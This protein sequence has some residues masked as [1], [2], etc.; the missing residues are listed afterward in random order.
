MAAA[1]VETDMKMKLFPRETAR[2]QPLLRNIIV[3]SASLL[4]T[5]CALSGGVE[6][7]DLTVT[8]SATGP[9][10]VR[11]SLPVPRGLIGSNGLV[12]VTI[13]G[14]V[15][16]PVG[17]RVLSWHPTSNGSS[18]SVRRALVTF[19]HRF[20]DSN[21]VRF[22]LR[23]TKTEA[24][25]AA[26]LPV[27]LVV[28]DD[29]FVLTWAGGQRSRLRF[30]APPRTSQELPRLELVEE[31]RFYRW[32]R[33]H[34][35]DADWPRVIEFRLDAAGGVV[36]VAHLQRGNTNG[37]F[38]PE[39]GWELTV[40]AKDASIQ[41]A[42]QVI[43]FD[44]NPV[45]HPFTSGMMATTIF[46]QQLA[47]YHPAAPLKRRGGITVARTRED[48]FNYAYMRSQAGEE[49]PMQFKSWQR[50][51]VVLAPPSLARLNPSLSYPHLVTVDPVFWAVLYGD[52]AKLPHLPPLLE[53]LLKYHRDAVMR[54]A[55][56]GDD[57]GNVTGFNHGD[58]HGPVFGM[59]RLNHCGAI[60]EDGWYGSDRRLTETA[61]LWCDN[62]YDQTIWWGEPERG[63]T[64]Y[65]NLTAINETPP[66]KEYMWRS[67]TSVNFCT[68]GYDNFWLAWEET[69]DPRMRE[70]L[71]AQV[72]YADRHVHA[73][74]GECRNIGDVRDF[75]R[76]HRFTG[77]PR[78]LEEALRL[79]RELRGKLS[80]GNLFDQGGKP[81]DPDPPFIEEDQGGLKVGYAK[82]YI[83]GYAL[84]GLPE[85]I[86]LAPN[87][88][89]L[90]ET[91]GAV[92]DFLAS[93][94]DASGGWRYPHPRSSSVLVNHGLE[95]AWHLTQ[96]ARALGPKTEWLDAIETVLRARVLCWRNSGQLPSGLVG[97]EMATGRVKEKLEIYSLYRKPFDRDFSRDYTEGTLT[98]GQMPP[99]GLVYFGEVLAYYLQ[100][101]PAPRLWVNP[102][103]DEPLGHLLR[104]LNTNSPSGNEAITSRPDAYQSPGIRDQLPIFA[105]QLAGRMA[106]PLSWL[107]WKFADFDAWRTAARKK[108]VE[109][110]L[111]HSPEVPFAPEVIAEQDR[112]S[113]IA[114][115]VIFNITADSRVLALMLVP[116]APGPHPAVLLLHDHGAKFDIGKEKVIASWDD[117][118][119][120]LE[121]ARKWVGQCY[122][123]KFLGDELARR[124]YV[125]LATDMLNWSDRGGGDF[126]HQQAVAANLLQL[127]SSW[128]GL[129]AHEDLRAA[130]FLATRPEVD[131][132]RVAAMGLSVGGYRTWQVAALSDRISAGVSVC[133]MATR[134]G[135][136]APKNNQTTGQSAFTMI[137]PGLAAYLDYPDVASVACPKPMMF[138]CGSRDHLF[139][140]QSIQEAFDKMR[141]VWG[142]RHADEALDLRLYDAP[143][144]F[145][146]AMQGDAFEWLDRRFFKQ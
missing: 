131:A 19:P 116:K 138:L 111:A 141:K 29:S 107:S 58:S 42:G 71:L 39:I 6:Q 115:K 96:A 99:E 133:W 102:K 57:F 10:L 22:K 119:E 34:F 33:L 82:P 137:H 109:C 47:V 77:E 81:L 104:R 65:N 2:G 97:W 105:D 90:R 95:N 48:S 27:Q 15:P 51:E 123:G 35:P 4:T 53:Q 122:G 37:H 126:E 130:E 94:V 24:Q 78:Y 117:T 32:Q 63:G 103:A 26:E 98:L 7:M 3:L 80:T 113:Y 85:L 89:D 100:H 110:Q 9:Q 125:C 8:P 135:L 25:S 55:V 30:K 18:L 92:A 114:W 54:S 121:S 67:D 120:K 28:E 106:Y 41:T 146:L 87:E 118:P 91:V 52:A 132:K 44:G 129:I 43:A 140:V 31:N 16:Q 72:A 5:L 46:D 139:P 36:V 128:A 64:R 14:G 124:G 60:F 75:V 86:P 93:T 61:L 50:A 66:T 83:I 74:R 143:H 23:K 45:S 108:I 49:I 68:K 17:L 101:R 40:N 13:E 134:K 112:G 21:P 11:A 56:V 88:P 69:G 84:A 144:E 76:L 127:G 70:A 12:S 79:F 136:M 38:A 142:S 62:F 73:D 59:N 1:E 20:A 145:N